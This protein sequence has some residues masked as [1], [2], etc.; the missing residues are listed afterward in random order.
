MRRRR[1]WA[2]R[3]MHEAR[4]HEANCFLTLTLDDKALPADRSLDVRHWQLFAKRARKRGLRFRYFMAGEYG[5][6][7]LRP[8]Y[9][10]CMFGEDFSADRFYFKDAPSGAP[11]FCSPLL[12]DLWSLG[13]A[14]IG[15]L[16]FDSACYVA[17]YCTKKVTGKNADAHYERVNL[18]TGETWK[19]RPEF[20]TMSRRPGL[21]SEFYRKFGKE[22]FDNDSVIYNGREAR[23]P[24][25]YDKLFSVDDPET[26]E[27]VKRGRIDRVPRETGRSRESAYRSRERVLESKLTLRSGALDGST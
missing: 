27:V 17:K 23:P 2:I 25:Y 14:S 13:F 7:K 9:H 1:D 18:A 22:V 15:T 19:V 6:E 10:A 11:L 4:E 12:N 20:A 16:T 8:H 24:R 26:Y 5:E 3:M 21:G